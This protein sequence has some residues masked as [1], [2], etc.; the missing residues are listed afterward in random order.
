MKF[1]AMAVAG[2]GRRSIRAGDTGRKPL[3]D[4]EEEDAKAVLF[5]IGLFITDPLLALGARTGAVLA[6]TQATPVPAERP[7][8]RHRNHARNAGFGAK[9]RSMRAPSPRP[10]VR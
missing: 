6:L 9:P 4:S 2:R 10:S 1:P 8:G 5:S 7:C 3:I